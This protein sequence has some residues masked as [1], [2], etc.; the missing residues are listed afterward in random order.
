MRVLRME[1]EIRQVVSSAT[2]S[3]SPKCLN[4]TQES[5][6][7]CDPHMTTLATTN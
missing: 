2:K 4:V 7:K 1:K 3:V 5:R 6:V